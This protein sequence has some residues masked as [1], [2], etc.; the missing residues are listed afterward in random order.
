MTPTPVFAPLFL[1]G[2][3][4]VHIIA[5]PHLPIAMPGA[6]FVFV[7]LVVIPAVVIVITVTVVPIV[8]TILCPHR[9]Y[10]RQKKSHP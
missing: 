8:I 6:I 9:R 5:M 2:A 10:D 4:P 7:P 1:V 3:P